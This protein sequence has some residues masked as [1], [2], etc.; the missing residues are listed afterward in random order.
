MLKLSIS[1]GCLLGTQ[2]AVAGAG[3]LVELEIKIYWVVD[4]FKIQNTAW[5][6]HLGAS[7][8]ID[9]G[10]FIACRHAGASLA[11]LKLRI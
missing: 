5:F 4:G 6:S 2:P 11:E 1:F 8:P 10:A 9:G 3:I 7:Y